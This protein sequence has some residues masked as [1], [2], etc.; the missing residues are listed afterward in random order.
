M[1]KRELTQ[2]AVCQIEEETDVISLGRLRN[3][4][5]EKTSEVVYV[6]KGNKLYG[7]IGMGEALRQDE[8]GNV[9]INKSFTSLSGYNVMK[10]HEI[11][12]D[13]LRI[14]KIPVVNEQGELVGDYSRW[15]D[16]LFIERN[17][18]VLMKEDAIKKIFEKYEA[19]YVIEPVKDKYSMYLKMLDYLD[20]FHIKYSIL[21]K[22]HFSEKLTECAICIFLDEDER[23]GI[24]CL[25]GIM[26]KTSDGQGYN[27]FRYDIPK[28]TRWKMRLATYKSL[29]EQIAENMQLD[30]L[31]IKK[32]FFLLY[33]RIDERAT[34]L[35]SALQRKGLKCM[36]ICQY[37][38]AKELTDYQ[39]SFR[40]EVFERSKVTPINLKAPWPKGESGEVFFG[41]LYQQEDYKNEIA[42]QK[43]WDAAQKFEYEEDVQGKYFNAKNG[44]RVTCFQ[45]EEYVGTIYLLGACT[46]IGSF[47]EDSQTIASFMQKK[48]LEKGYNFRVENLGTLVYVTSIE[49]RLKKIQE[50]H[51]NDIVVMMDNRGTVGIPE[52]SLEDI[53]DRHKIPVKW[54][55]DMYAHCNW[56]TNQIIA[57]DIL[58]E[59]QSYLS[60]DI[61]EDN[62]VLH[63]DIDDIMHEY[64][65]HQYLDKYFSDF[66]CRNHK[67]TGAIV[68]NGNP[69]TKGHRYLVEQ[70][71]Q[72]VDFLIVFVIEENMFPFSFEERF[73]MVMDGTKDLDRIMVVPSGKFILSM[74]NFPEYFTHRSGA[75]VR[76]HAE[77]DITMFADH[78]AKVLHITYRFAGEESEDKIKMI[79]NEVMREILPQKGIK[80]VEIPKKTEK[81]ESITGYRVIRYLNYKE[82]DKAFAMVSNDTKQ[83]LI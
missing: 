51:K 29:L 43:I 34:V 77:Y 75:A 20:C 45:P 1:A 22:E 52:L 54:V 37:N 58:D 68:I 5:L 46:I 21:S 3:L 60:N 32:P 18:S 36:H 25:Y 35:L 69:F 28:D 76:V 12:Q 79:Y 63:I 82:Y 78:V 14:H 39:E 49:N 9:F 41:E 81:G 59:M 13:K 17:H 66:C 30:R 71:R 70:A 10:A 6:N 72:F 64:V 40:R 26:P 74:N 67:K 8:K 44:K 19:I 53:F 23:R 65:Q 42:Q 73:R 57:M 16:L 55:T 24:Q 48:L 11:F 2:L 31:N 80:F 83:Y 38:E 33:D 56:K 47:E 7:I 62:E 15:E 4:Y 27:N 50:F 61:K